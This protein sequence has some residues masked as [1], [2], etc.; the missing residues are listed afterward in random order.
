MKNLLHS[1]G[2]IKDDM[3]MLEQAHL[4][5]TLFLLLK[6]KCFLPLLSIE[7]DTNSSFLSFSL[8]TC[9]YIV[10]KETSQSLLS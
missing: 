6:V 8:L 3:S 7:P 2:S 1:S 9:L 4:Q 10:V 5:Y